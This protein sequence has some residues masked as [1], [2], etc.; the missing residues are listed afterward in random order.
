M[1]L[2][3]VYGERERPEKLYPKLIDA[4]LND[5]I[6]PLYEGSEKHLR[7]YSY[8]GDIV[9]GL[10]KVLDDMSGLNGNI[11]NLGTDKAITT[12]QGIAI[13]EELLGKKTKIVVQPKRP[14]DQL[15]T[16]ANIEKARKAFAYDPKTT[17]E[18]G[19]RKEVEWFKDKIWKKINLYQ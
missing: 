9:D 2:F 12:G 16:H 7:S 10:V 13:V 3:S 8:V 17:P 14:G 19:L 5:K 6:F 4:I 15:E 18:E 11:F 1:R